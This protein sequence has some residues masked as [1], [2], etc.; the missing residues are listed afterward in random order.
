MSENYKLRVKSDH[1]E[2]EMESGDR[3]FVE[4]RMDDLFALASK[5]VPRESNQ[6]ALPAQ[7]A[8]ARVQAPAQVQTAPQPQTLAPSASSASQTRQSEEPR[9]RHSPYPTSPTAAKDE[10]DTFEEPKQEIKSR[11]RSMSSS[12]LKSRDRLASQGL[13]FISESDN[14][15]DTR[16]ILHAIENSPSYE[17]LKESVINQKDQLN[18]ILLVFYFSNQVYPDKT[19][20]NNIIED[21]TDKIGNKISRVNIGPKIKTNLDLFK[22]YKERKQ[23]G[24]LRYQIKIAGLERFENLID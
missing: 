24:A 9:Q 17:D 13:D 2:I 11:R 4:S 6:P 7:A 3:Q 18:R 19:L 14:D 22:I 23:G 20:S 10:N 12:K 21:V 1:F 8:P 15:I 5:A 16:K